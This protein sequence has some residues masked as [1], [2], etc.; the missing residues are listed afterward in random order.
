[1]VYFIAAICKDS[2][3]IE[4]RD[5]IH[6]VKPIVE[7]HGGRYLIRSEKIKT[8]H[9]KWK[10]ERVVIIEWEA[11]NQLESCFSSPEYKKIAKKREQNVV[12]IAVIVEE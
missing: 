2:D 3:N 12:S 1:M 7:K 6:Q 8:L 10:A 9:T 4:Y 5:Y 11:R